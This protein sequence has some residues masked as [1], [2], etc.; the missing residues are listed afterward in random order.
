MKQRVPC[1]IKAPQKVLV[2][3]TIHVY[4]RTYGDVLYLRDCV[5]CVM[6]ATPVDT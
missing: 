1:K 3:Q 5:K 2:K 4:L 6:L